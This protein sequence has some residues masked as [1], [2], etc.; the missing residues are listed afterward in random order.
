MNS[1]NNLTVVIVT[2]LTQKKILLEC[3]NSINKEVKIKIIENSENFEFKREILNKFS[4]VEITCTGKNLGYGNG[5]NFGLKLT[6]TDFALILNPDL[7]CDNNFFSNLN[8]MLQ[9]NRDFSIIG[10]QYIYDKVFMPAGFFDSKK[11]NVFK[12]KFKNNEIVPLEKVDWV[13]GCSMLINLKQFENKEIFDKNFFLYFE[14]FDLCKS[15]IDKGNNVF[16]S[17]DLKIHHLGFQSSLGNDLKNLKRANRMIE[18]HWMWSSFYFYKK[19]YGL[20]KATIKMSGKFF[21]SFFKLIFYFLTF[22]NIKKDKYLHIFFGL[23]N[24]MIGKPSSFRDE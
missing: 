21:K 23:F 22:Q 9:K 10:C 15:I 19:N 13:T 2:Y 17:S 7:V 8:S 4:N 6:Q 20:F 18:W 16:T 5:N 3:L 11:N 1:L 24:A 14:E 12:K